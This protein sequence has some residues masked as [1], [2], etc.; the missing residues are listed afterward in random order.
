M[1]KAIITLSVLCGFLLLQHPTQEIAFAQTN[2]N[3]MTEQKELT[4]QEA[5]NLLIKYNNKVNYIFQGNADQ[6]ET[7]KSKNL[8]GYVFLPDVETDIGYFVDKSTSDIYFFHPSGY[9]E[10]IKDFNI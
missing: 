8:S 10:L 2:T 6:F 9:L 4:Q 5:S 3:A 7:L 1:R